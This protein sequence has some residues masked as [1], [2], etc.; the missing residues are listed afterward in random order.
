MQKTKNNPSL[1]IPPFCPLCSLGCPQNNQVFFGSNRNKPKLNLLWL[2]FGLFRKTKT[3]FF[4]FVQVFRTSIKTTKT[5]TFSKQ[6]KKIPK[7]PLY[8]G[9]LETINFFR[10]EPKQTETRSVSVVFGVCG[11]QKIIFW[12]VSVCLGVSD[13]YRNNRNKPKQ[14]K[15][16]FLGFRCCF[17]W[18]F[19]YFG[20]FETPKLPVSIL[21]RNNRN[22]RLVSDRAETSFA[23][24]DTKIVQEDT[25]VQSS[26]GAEW[27]Q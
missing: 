18:S 11:S 14:T 20:C 15:K 2:F 7:N 17:S 16:L 5:N 24:F 10:F 9:V 13:R 21:K 25:L 1:A 8:Q 27:L 26:Q 3:F 12:F 23:C 19:V 6:T 22:K 4:R